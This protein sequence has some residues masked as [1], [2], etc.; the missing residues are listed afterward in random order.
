MTV[1]GKGLFGGNRT[2]AAAVAHAFR[3]RPEPHRGRRPIRA[4]K[5]S[6]AAG[7]ALRAAHDRMVLAFQTAQIQRDCP[8]VDRRHVLEH[9]PLGDFRR[10]QTVN[11]ILD[12]GFG[13][14]GQGGGIASEMVAQE[15]VDLLMA[16]QAIGETGPAR[17]LPGRLEDR[18]EQGSQTAR[19][20][21]QPRRA[22]FEPAPIEVGVALVEIIG[23]HNDRQRRAVR[24]DARPQ[25]REPL[26]K[27]A[28]VAGDRHARR[29]QPLLGPSGRGA[30]R[31]PIRRSSRFHGVL[32]RN[33]ISPGRKRRQRP[34]DI[35]RRICVVEVPDDVALRAAAVE[36]RQ[37]IAVDLPAEQRVEGFG[38][39]ERLVVVD[40]AKFKMWGKHRHI[41]R[42]AFGGRGPAEHPAPRVLVG[43][44]LAVHGSRDA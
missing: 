22:G 34:A 6:V 3:A 8:P 33:D 21:Q 16:A 41:D 23:A 44:W 28:V 40:R 2:Q 1:P 42:A 39:K 14:A 26:D 37:K 20:D 30:E 35:R 25:R 19:S 36:Q 5:S 27:A 12:R 29:R 32:A 13:G 17:S 9:Q 38:D 18:A 7:G 11:G 15:A 24:A 4:R 43:G 31:R 10:H